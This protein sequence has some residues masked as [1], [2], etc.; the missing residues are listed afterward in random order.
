MFSSGVEP[1]LKPLTYNSFQ[2]F[3]QLTEKFRP[4]L[5]PLLKKIDEDE[6]IWD[7]LCELVKPGKSTFSC[8]C[9]G[10][11]RLNNIFIE[12]SSPQPH[13]LP[14]NATEDNECSNDG[15]AYSLNKRTNSQEE[16]EA[17]VGLRFID[18]QLT[19]YANPSTDLQYCIHMST[20]REF[21][22]KHTDTALE[23]YYEEFRAVL[24]RFQGVKLEQWEGVE[25]WT[26]EKLKEEYN[27]CYMYGF[28]VSVILLPMIL[29]RP[30]VDIDKSMS[31]MT[32]A[33]RTQ[34]FHERADL[35]L[36]I[37]SK[38]DGMRQRLFELCDEMVAKNVIPTQIL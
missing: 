35:V 7:R 14:T 19:R 38:N 8:L 9:H 22:E 30:E 28:L 25:G 13:K 29:L 1:A 21:R 34:F 11:P 36:S 2:G 27:Q 4:D 31:Q 16:K 26:L 3:L 32:K 10:D 6:N 23:T 15:S 33:E 12:K 5:F 17:E 24:G 20:S 37:G 18:F